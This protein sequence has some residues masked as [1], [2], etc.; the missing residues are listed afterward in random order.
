LGG[1]SA[2]VYF[3][4]VCNLIFALGYVTIQFQSA[5]K[6]PASLQFLNRARA[7]LRTTGVEKA[8]AAVD[9]VPKGFYHGTDVL[10]LLYHNPA[11]RDRLAS[12]PP[13]L[14]LYET[15]E[16]QFIFLD[17]EFNR[18]LNAKLDLVSL[19][20]NTN[21]VRM[22]KSPLI[23]KQLEQVDVKDLREYLETGKSPKY[24][25]MKHLGH[26]ELF[27]AAT[28]IQTGRVFPRVGNWPV[29][30]AKFKALA[31]NKLPDIVMLL[32]AEGQII[33]KATHVDLK[34]LTT[35][36]SGK[37]PQDFA[38]A[39][40]LPVPGA[41]KVIGKGEWKKEGDTYTVTLKTDG[42]EKAGKLKMVND[43][44]FVIELPEGSMTFIKLD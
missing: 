24:A 23:T 38:A 6:T 2:V 21:V 44:S 30:W 34:Q 37:V 29:E 36:V 42:L 22:I 14:G 4:L 39:T 8:A 10:G 5:T 32:G 15:P 7:D 26:W 27:P 33:V 12:Y 20:E 40:V 43:E 31:A 16:Y 35:L 13:F 1:V 28:I 41:Q 17:T 11:L 25:E 19:L 18:I 3:L 9:P